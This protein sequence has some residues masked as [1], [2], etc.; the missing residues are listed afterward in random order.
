[1]I[2]IIDHYDSFTY[3][4]VHYLKDFR[5]DV[6]YPKQVK[7]EEL[8]KYSHIILSP[9]YGHPKDC[10]VALRVLQQYYK[11]K[12]ILGVCLGHQTIAL[13]F[14]SKIAG[15]E[16][17]CH[18]KSSLI[19]SCSGRL[20]HGIEGGFQVGRYHSLYVEELGKDLEAS[21]YTQDGVLMAFE[22]RELPIFGVQFHPESILSDC[23]KQI[24][25]NF[26]KTVN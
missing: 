25:I 9:G 1:M 8:E 21:C 22:H 26:I 17:P 23:G 20:F 3:N 6:F 4:I 10:K 19:T 11:S 15:L 14:K 18:G 7:L 16:F 13:F 5:V 12:K 2:A 24:L